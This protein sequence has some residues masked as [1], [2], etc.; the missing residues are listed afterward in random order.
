MKKTILCVCAQI[1]ALGATLGADSLLR[2]EETKCADRVVASSFGYDATDATDALQRAIDSGA[3]TVVVDKQPTPWIVRPINLRNNLQLILEEGVEILAK[4]GEFQN[5]GDVLLR[6]VETRNVRIVG[7]G[8]GA[9]LRMRKRDYWR[10]PYKKSEWRHGIS[11]LS[12]QD[13][14]IENLTIAETGGDGVYLGDPRFDPAFAELDRRGA[15]VILHPSPARS[16]P[17]EGVVTGGVMALYEYPA[18]TTRA[19]VNLLANRTLEK[20][21]HIRLVVPHC[22]SFLPY[23]KSRAGGMFR[24]L[25]AMGRMEPVD[26]EAGMK[27]LWFDLAGDPTPDQMDMLLRITDEHHIVYGSDYPYVLAPIVLQR[28]KAL[29]EVLTQ[30]GQSGRFYTENAEKLLA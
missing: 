8:R 29:D 25:S 19:V 16:L 22:G 27:Q 28:K 4:E 10:A 17:R 24:L 2:A 1:I 14:V 15:L 26:M 23:M 20:F 9:T 21:P 18:D 30:R 13:V 11:L 12:A 7:E 3:K 5:I 6:A